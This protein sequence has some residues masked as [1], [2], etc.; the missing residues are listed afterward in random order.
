MASDGIEVSEKYSGECIEVEYGVCNNIQCKGISI[1][2][3]TPEA[4]SQMTL[5]ELVA[6]IDGNP[7]QNKSKNNLAK[8][9]SKTAHSSTADSSVSPSRVSDDT[10]DLESEIE[11]FRRKLEQTDHITPTKRVKLRLNPDWVDGLRKEINA[12]RLLLNQ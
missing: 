7:K 1:I 10:N 12:R 4:I 5:D 3:S 9:E 2:Q 11:E 8:H 6:F